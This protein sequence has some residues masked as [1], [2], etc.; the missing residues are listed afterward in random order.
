MN[1]EVH[2]TKRVKTSDGLRFC[3]VIIAPNGIVGLVQERLH[4]RRKK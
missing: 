2:L 3:P 1:R 4:A